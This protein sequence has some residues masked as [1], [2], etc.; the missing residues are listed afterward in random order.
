MLCECEMYD[1]FKDLNTMGVKV[2]VNRDVDVNDELGKH[3]R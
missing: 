3:E 2:D 1:E